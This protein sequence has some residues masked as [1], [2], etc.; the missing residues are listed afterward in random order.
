ML[1]DF[2]PFIFLIFIIITIIIIIIIAVDVYTKLYLSAVKDWRGKGMGS[3]VQLVY[4]VGII[5]ELF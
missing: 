5:I 4:D 2:F 3:R 1:S